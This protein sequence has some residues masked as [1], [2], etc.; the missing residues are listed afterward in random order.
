MDQLQFLQA[1][2]VDMVK[3]GHIVLQRRA[4]MQ[5]ILLK[6]SRK[7]EDMKKQIISLL[8]DLWRLRALPRDALDSMARTIEL[9]VKPMFRQCTLPSID[10]KKLVQEAIRQ[11][12]APAGDKENVNY[13]SRSR[14]RNSQLRNWHRHDSRSPL[15]RRTDPSAARSKS[16]AKPGSRIALMNA[17]Q[18]VLCRQSGV[19]LET[20]RSS[21]APTVPDSDA[22]IEVPPRQPFS[23]PHNGHDS[24]P[25]DHLQIVP[26]VGT[27]NLG[28]H[29]GDF[30]HHDMSVAA[31]LAPDAPKAFS[32]FAQHRVKWP[33]YDP[34]EITRAQVRQFTTETNEDCLDFVSHCSEGIRLDKSYLFYREL[35]KAGIYVDVLYWGSSFQKL[36]NSQGYKGSEAVPAVTTRLGP[37]INYHISTSGRVRLDG[38]MDQK[39]V[40]AAMLRRVFP[41]FYGT[42]L[43]KHASALQRH[44]VDGCQLQDWMAQRHGKCLRIEDACV[45]DGFGVQGLWDKLNMAVGVRG[46]PANTAIPWIILTK[47]QVCIAVWPTGKIQVSP[48]KSSVAAI[49][50]VEATL[51]NHFNAK[52]VPVG[53]FKQLPDPVVTYGV[54][55]ETA[56]QQTKLFG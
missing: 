9:V 40:L 3:G 51:V 16:M 22:E 27:K 10:W 5:E 17:E 32:K 45:F 7:R 13:R 56:R 20:P 37:S 36:I 29:G 44:Q 30:F 2:G 39:E 49:E 18:K 1:F 8:L 6:G 31:A 25:P 11:F 42:Q 23:S 46:V 34:H 50:A 14:Q 47:T 15:Q 33:P 12:E 53:A 28:A 41:P 54:L 48:C 26:C 4:V 52:W 55:S 43:K 21:C 24:V 38:K 19:L 35:A